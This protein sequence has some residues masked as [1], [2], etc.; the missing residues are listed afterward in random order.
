M[1]GR[2]AMKSIA[3]VAKQAAAKA[4]APMVQPRRPAPPPPSMSTL[5]GKVASAVRSVVNAP[6]AS[7][8]AGAFKP[9]NQIAP[10]IMSAVSNA[11]R[12]GKM[13]KSGGKT[14]KSSSK[15]SNW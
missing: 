15:K 6:K 3:N 12:A 2:N 10:K 1:F 11:A 4:P 5:P 7:A 8:P 13:M 9:M 14:S